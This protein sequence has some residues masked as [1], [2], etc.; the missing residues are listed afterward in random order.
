MI[1]GTIGI[2]ILVTAAMGVGGG[3]AGSAAKTATGVID[4]FLAASVEAGSVRC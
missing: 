3:A 1:G 2:A 4:A